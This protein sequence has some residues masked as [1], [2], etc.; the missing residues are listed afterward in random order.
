MKFTL[1]AIAS[2]FFG[3]SAFGAE[4]SLTELQAASKTATELFASKNS[5]HLEFVT[6]FKVWKAGDDA[7]VRVYMTHHGSSMD[8]D[9]TCFRA[10]GAID[11]RQD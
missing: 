8:V 2:L 7:K 4:F 3:L 11:C 5:G 1:S 6:G 10:A 9:Y